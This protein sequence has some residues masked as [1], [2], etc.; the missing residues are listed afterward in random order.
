MLKC[1]ARPGASIP[2]SRKLWKVRAKKKPAGEKGGGGTFSGETADVEDYADV[3][4]G[5]QDNSPNS[6]NAP[7]ARVAPESFRRKYQVIIAW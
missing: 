4:R 6:S 7:C 1:E 3:I 5:L 2:N